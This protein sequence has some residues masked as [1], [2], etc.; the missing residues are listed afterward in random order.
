MLA[1]ILAC[2]LYVKMSHASRVFRRF[3]CKP[4]PKSVTDIKVD[5][6]W[7]LSGHRYVMHFK[8]S[9]D[10]IALILDSRP[11]RQVMNVEYGRGFFS[12]DVD[13]SHGESLPLYR[14]SE[15]QLGPDWF[16]PAEWANPKCYEFRESNLDYR[17]HIQV[18]IYNEDIGEAFVVEYQEGY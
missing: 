7:E 10:D 1:V 4:I 5:H 18:L 11:F 2:V 6:P 12:W 16:R 13:P 17:E 14:V 15:G 3:V 9:K 8:I